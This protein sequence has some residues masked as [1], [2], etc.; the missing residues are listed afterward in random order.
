MK[1]KIDELFET[2]WGNEYSTIKKAAKE[3]PN[4]TSGFGNIGKTTKDSFQIT[5]TEFHKLIEIANNREIEI[6]LS[7]ETEL[8][9]H[10]EKNKE[11]IRIGKL[12]IK[13]NDQ[14]LV[15]DAE[16][17]CLYVLNEEQQSLIQFIFDFFQKEGRWPFGSEI[18]VGLKRTKIKD[19][20]KTLPDGELIIYE[21]HQGLYKL[22][23]YGIA[24]ATGSEPYMDAL[25]YVAT[26]LK[27]ALIGGNSKTEKIVYDNIKGLNI[28]SSISKNLITSLLMYPWG[29]GGSITDDFFE[30][31]I[32]KDD[33]RSSI[34]LEYNNPI[35]FCR[36]RYV[37]DEVNLPGY[38]YDLNSIPEVETTI[39]KLPSSHFN[40]EFLNDK[41]K[42]KCVDHFHSGKFDE[43]VFIACKVIEVRTRELAQLKNTDIGIDLMRKAFNPKN[44]R[45]KYSEIV[46]EQESV[47]HLFS[48]FIGTF[49]NPHS[50]RFIGI[51]DPLTA[52]E[53][54][55]FANHLYEILDKAKVNK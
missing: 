35:S 34:I 10:L 1:T 23:M 48:G 52:F 29:A 5:E 45:L 15:S 38:L 28:V 11:K 6:I 25:D 39:D 13:M 18:L 53:I 20:I 4:T 12:P 43:A 16:V 30:I 26:E 51:K 41:L 33:N 36:S 42:E 31:D 46:A 2:L 19:I 14:F 47:M 32:P 8:R 24:H 49:K 9:H 37:R 3:A 50:H 55:S 44:P 22:T 40:L 17:C 27:K 21:E 54:I 7:T